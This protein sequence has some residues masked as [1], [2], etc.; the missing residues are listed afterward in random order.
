VPV[1]AWSR[2][3]LGRHT[4]SQ[5]LAGSFLG[6]ATVIIILYLTNVI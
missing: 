5:T 3:R 4:I 1:I 6:A 2:I